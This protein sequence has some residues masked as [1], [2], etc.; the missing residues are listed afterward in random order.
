MT[1]LLI[2]VLFLIGFS[3]FMYGS[4]HLIAFESSKQG[5]ISVIDALKAMVL[6]GI[7]IIVMS[8]FLAWHL[9]LLDRWINLF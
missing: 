8:Y 9:G 4:K 2:I 5:D 7:S 1:G 6:F 3:A